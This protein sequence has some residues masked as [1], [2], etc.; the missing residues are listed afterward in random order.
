MAKIY[1]LTRGTTEQ[2]KED[3]WLLIPLTPS[4]FNAAAQKLDQNWTDS[5]HGAG[6]KPDSFVF[7]NSLAEI[8]VVLKSLSDC[9]I[10]LEEVDINSGKQNPPT[11][12]VQS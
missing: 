6:S 9:G 2:V 1:K 8:S 12:A 11:S 4:A 3:E 5:L 7:R 10:L